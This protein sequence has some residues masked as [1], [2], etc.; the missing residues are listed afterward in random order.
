MCCGKKAIIIIIIIIR[1]VLNLI[2]SRSNVYYV[3]IYLLLLTWTYVEIIVTLDRLG[4]LKRCASYG[5]GV[6][7]EL[8]MVS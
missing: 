4:G 8:G 2:H 6:I 1:N 7:H 3:T 5:T